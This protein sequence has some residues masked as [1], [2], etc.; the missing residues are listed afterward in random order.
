EAISKKFFD[1]NNLQ[2][3]PD[4]IVVSTGAKQSLI[5]VVMCLVNPGEEVILPAPYW[6]SYKAMVQ[7]AE[8][9]SVIVP[10]TIESD[11]KISPEQLEAAITPKTKLI[12]FS[13]PCNPSGTV[14]S[15]DELKALADVIALHKDLFVV[16]DEIY[17]KINFIGKHTS[18]ASF[19]NIKDRVI[20]VNGLSKGYA[21]TGWRLGYIGAPLFIAKACDK[22]QGQF[23]SATNSIAQRTIIDALQ[24]SQQ[25]SEEMKK[26]FLKRREICLSHLKKIKGL[27]YNIPQG[28]F[29]FFP[30][31][32][33]YFS[34]SF[35]GKRINNAD[36]LCMYLLNEAN[37][38]L[39]T[40]S[41][42]GDNNC[43]RISY[44]TSEEN[45]EKGM[46]RLSNALAQLS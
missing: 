21:M 44:A 27:K 39:V 14:Y 5:N 34:K 17:E 20:V 31:V 10:T 41:A 15:H 24:G 22:L 2:F 7:M 12:I 26:A 30:D 9:V 6:V 33:N 4:Q 45:L 32:S 38:S 16:S 8:G 11:F 19:E 13:S 46:Q 29:Y 37:V 3:T 28:A 18:I 23:T 1:E 42:F 40:G 35:N 36:D 25:P 43:V